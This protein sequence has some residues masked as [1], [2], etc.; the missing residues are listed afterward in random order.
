M[1]DDSTHPD[2]SRYTPEAFEEAFGEPLRQTLDL[3]TWRAGLDLA[4]EHRRIEAEVRHAVEQETRHQ[5]GIRER[6]FPR[7]AQAG[8]APRGAGVYSVPL[9]E[10]AEVQRGLLFSGGVECCDGN[11]QTHDTLPLT[12]HQI[13]VSLVSYNGDQGSWSHRLFRRNLRVGSGDPEQELLEILER[14]GRRGAL[15][16]P[17]DGE[18]FS[19]LFQRALMAYAERA[20][21]ARRARAVWRM[22]HGSPAPYELLNASGCA[23]LMVESLRIIRE[24]VERHQ[25][26]VF[27]ASEPG[28]RALVMIGQ[29]L[30]PLEYAVVGTLAERLTRVWIEES[31]FSPT[32]YAGADWDGEYLTPP[33]WLRRF[34]D[35]VAPQVVYGFYRATALAPPQLFYAHVD[36]ADLAARVALADSALQELRGFPLLIDVADD[37]CRS[38]YGGATLRDLAVNAYA[39]VGAPWRYLSERS[40]RNR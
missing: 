28:N 39:A 2:S 1:A 27:I 5:R 37:V 3:E 30:H 25:K 23:E 19:E 20:V 7:I 36:H 16:H 21:L 29:A 14:R 15:N 4:R 11:I 31:R 10:L 33:Q 34:R 17:A 26:F 13:G 6:V 8:H 32:V 40:T 24:L 35:R 38:V 18:A 12:I 22:G 9:E